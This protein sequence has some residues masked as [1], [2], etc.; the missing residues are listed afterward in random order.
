MRDFE[1][2]AEGKGFDLSAM[3]DVQ[4]AAL[5]A[6]WRAESNPAP[7]PA[8]VPTPVPDPEP[9]SGGADLDEFVSR[10]R[11]EHA[12]QRR[13]TDIVSQAI[14]EQP[15]KLDELETIGRAAIKGK[16]TEQQTELAVL[17]ACRA[18]APSPLRQATATPPERVLEAAIAQ[19][20]RLPSAEQAYDERTMEAA[21]KAFK[22][23]LGLQ[24]LLLIAAQANGYR[25]S[26]PVKSNLNEVMRAAFTPRASVLSTISVS[27]ILSNVANKFL[28]D[29]FM[30]VEQVWS[31]IAA[32]RSFSD[33][34]T[35]TTYSM[36]GDATFE[37]IPPGG[38]IPHGT[39]GETSYTNQA[40]SYGKMHGLDRRDLINDDLGA[41]NAVG[42][43]LGRGG[44]IKLNKV[45]W[46]IFLNNSSFFTSGNA[47]VSTGAGSAL[48]LAGLNAAYVKF[49]LLTDP[50][51]NLMGSDAKLLLVPPAL[52]STGRDLMDSQKKVATTTANAGLPDGNPFAGLWE[53]VSSAYM[54]DSTLTGN[55]DA[56]WYLLADPMDVPVIE[57]GFLNGQEMP[58]VESADAD[59]NQLGVQFRGYYDF[60]VA[61]QEFRG[62]VRSAGS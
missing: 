61:L 26:A 20:A 31:R 7:A 53:V 9:G 55:S 22:G 17:R 48:A 2:W 59:F 18:S 49:K 36:S 45:F 15:G 13:V 44:A 57:V 29:H 14:E 1:Q 52:W 28:R 8:P 54:Q 12:R 46:G 47:N 30:A 37:E 58:T 19:A 6:A 38:T 24:Q 4:V 3:S 60:G 50:D 43:R 10:Q 23:G 41:F 40:K 33:F 5:R 27:G 34:K 21:H 11:A 42:K 32:R 25:G 16:W 62:G 51:G 56:A 35:V 39:L